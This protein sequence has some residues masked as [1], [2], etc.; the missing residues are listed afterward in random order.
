VQDLFGGV[1]RRRKVVGCE[2]RQRRGLAQALMLE[3]L[4]VQRLAQEPALQAV[5]QRVWGQ[6]H[7]GSRGRRHAR[8]RVRRT[9]RRE[10][11]LHARR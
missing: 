8:G 3:L 5:R 7:R 11:W 10:P 6:R 2:H 4:A 9:A 1:R